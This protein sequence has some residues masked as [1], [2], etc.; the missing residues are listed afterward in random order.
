[1]SSVDF[2]VGTWLNVTGYICGRTVSPQYTMDVG[3]TPVYSE[4]SIRSVM[5]WNAA[6]IDLGVYETALTARKQSGTTG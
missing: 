5:I 4:V 3:T 6:P 2:E 1:M